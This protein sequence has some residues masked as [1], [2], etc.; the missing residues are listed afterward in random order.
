MDIYIDIETLRSPETHRLQI[1]D[2]V[3]EKFKAPS[4]QSKSKTEENLI[5]H[6]FAF[7]PGYRIKLSPGL[8]L[9]L[10]LCV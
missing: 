1:I 6:S 3:K 4:K 10:H 2:D 5:N 9:H 8:Y 7:K